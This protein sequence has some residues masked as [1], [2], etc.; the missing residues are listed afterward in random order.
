M[1]HGYPLKNLNDWFDA[2]IKSKRYK[3]K[4]NKSYA[5]KV[6]YFIPW[7]SGSNC[8]RIFSQ[9]LNRVFQDTPLG[10]FEISLLGIYNML[11][12]LKPQLVLLTQKKFISL[13]KINTII[14]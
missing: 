8:W 7:A 9:F 3:T 13:I 2:T 6:R 14:L 4:V 11:A 10:Y 5:K 1:L 12:S